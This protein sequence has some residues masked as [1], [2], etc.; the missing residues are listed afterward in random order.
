[1]HLR[2]SR[3][4]D[5]FA[6]G[7]ADG[8]QHATLLTNNDL[9][10]TIARDKDGLLNARRAIGHFFPLIRFDGDLI[11]Q[12]IMQTLENFLARDFSRQ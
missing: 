6:S 11:G 5:L 10:L 1:M 3:F 12:L 7:R 8:F 9:L 2:L 4:H